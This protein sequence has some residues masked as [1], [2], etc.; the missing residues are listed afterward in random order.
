MEND[1]IRTN[2]LKLK[3]DTFK[4]EMRHKFSTMGVINQWTRL[5]KEVVDCPSLEVFR[6]TLVAFVEDML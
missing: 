3:P 1:G 2:G 5:S 4:L 6:S